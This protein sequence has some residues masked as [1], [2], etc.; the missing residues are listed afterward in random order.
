MYNGYMWRRRFACHILSLHGMFRSKEWIQRTG[1]CSGSMMPVFMNDTIL[2]VT[3]SFL[4]LLLF[5]CSLFE[6]FTLQYF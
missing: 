3:D 5:T 4:P 1:L 6:M 2:V